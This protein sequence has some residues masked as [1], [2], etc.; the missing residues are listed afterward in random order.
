[1]TVEL[2]Y[3]RPVGMVE[4]EFEGEAGLLPVDRYGVLLPSRDFS[5]GDAK[6]LPRIRVAS[7]FPASSTGSPWGDER[8]AGACRLAELLL[9]EW[10]ATPL[11]C[12]VALPLPPGATP[13]ETQYE[14]LT[15]GERHIVW[16]L[17]PGKEKI[18]EADAQQKRL[19][20]L[21]TL[22][23]PGKETSDLRLP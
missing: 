8:V 9:E 19:R 14:L 23:T 4:V 16:G 20:L 12:I 21:E 1:M 15:R 2:V 17:P 18:G 6:A 13:A 22:R 5:P 10:N 11:H 7:T 3:R